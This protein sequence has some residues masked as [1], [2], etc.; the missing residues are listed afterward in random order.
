MQSQFFDQVEHAW[1]WTGDAELETLLRP[2]LEI[3]C[4]YNQQCFDPQMTGVMLGGTIH[5]VA[6]VVGAGYSVSALVGNTAV[7]VKLFRV[8]LLLPTVLGLLVLVVLIG[9][10]AG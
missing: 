4:E 7:I 10:F 1:Q 5:D 3:Q 2:A 6:Q 9:S 8:L